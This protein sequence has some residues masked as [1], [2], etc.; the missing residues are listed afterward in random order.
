MR[1][2][3][4]YYFLPVK[5]RLLL[6]LLIP[7]I[8]IAVLEIWLVN[9][10]STFGLEISKLEQAAFALETENQLLKNEIDKQSSLISIENKARSLGFEKVKNIEYII[11]Q[12]SQVIVSR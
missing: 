3:E 9:R 12:D 10:L 5:K 2:L 8:V 7:I 4:I 11:Y 1:L 6:T